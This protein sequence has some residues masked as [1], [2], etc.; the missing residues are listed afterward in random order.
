MGIVALVGPKNTFSFF[1]KKNKIK[2]S[3][4]YFGGM[5]MIILG[6]PFFTLGGFVL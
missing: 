1:A 6:W 2:G 5:I 3:A 4:F